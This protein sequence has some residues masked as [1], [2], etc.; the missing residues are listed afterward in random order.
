MLNCC[1]YS[2][3]NGQTGL[4]QEGAV[5]I[6]GRAS[7]NLAPTREEEGPTWAPLGPHWGHLVFLDPSLL[8]NVF[9]FNFQLFSFPN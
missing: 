3:G 6:T 5:L 7:L 2:R 9:S 8:S 1:L 4:K